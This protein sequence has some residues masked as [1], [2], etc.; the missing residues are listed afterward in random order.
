MARSIPIIPRPH[1]GRG[2]GIDFKRLI[3]PFVVA[4]RVKVRSILSQTDLSRLGTLLALP[5]WSVPG[6]LAVID[7]ALPIL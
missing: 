2:Q 3:K 6:Q 4:R 7:L 5:L 1:E